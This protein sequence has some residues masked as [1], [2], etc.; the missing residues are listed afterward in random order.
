MWWS[1]GLRRSGDAE[2]FCVFLLVFIVFV[3]VAVF[4]VVV[5]VG[6]L[7]VDLAVVNVINRDGMSIL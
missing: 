5:A 4:I 7:I 3:A 1:G 6:V 2:R